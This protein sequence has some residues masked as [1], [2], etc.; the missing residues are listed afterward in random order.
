M[1]THYYVVFK[2]ILG[3]VVDLEETRGAVDRAAREAEVVE[4]VRD[5]LRRQTDDEEAFLVRISLT[6]GTAVP[7]VGA[8]Q[9][10]SFTLYLLC[11]T[12]QITNVVRWKF[13]SGDLKQIAQR[14]VNDLLPTED[15]V[16]RKV[17]LT[18]HSAS[19]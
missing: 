8:A 15:I 2:D 6:E 13:Q 19:K 7:V 3:L 4:A 17:S 9:G 1:F 10:N 14:W 11:R 18:H 5:L 12:S 16:V